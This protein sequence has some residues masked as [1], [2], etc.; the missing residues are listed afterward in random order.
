MP[1]VRSKSPRRIA[2]SVDFMVVVPAALTSPTNSRPVAPASPPTS[3]ICNVP[4]AVIVPS[5]SIKLFRLS[6]STPTLAANVFASIT[7]S[8][9]CVT[10]S[11]ISSPSSLPPNTSVP[12]WA[13]TE[14]R[15][16]VEAFCMTT[17]VALVLSVSTLPSSVN[18]ESPPSSV[19]VPDW[20]SMTPLVVWVTPL[21]SSAISP[22]ARI[23][24]SS[25]IRVAALSGS[26]NVAMRTP[27]AD[28]T[29][30]ATR[31]PPVLS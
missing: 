14:L 23:S 8:V 28:C 27:P 17:A 30:P 20:A 3:T 1:T 31:K 19:M 10:D 26:T 7:E 16:T 2:P 5:W 22:L 13:L 11:L 25:K 9:V 15:V 29:S 6:V 24:L 18:T 21:P 12:C 4:L